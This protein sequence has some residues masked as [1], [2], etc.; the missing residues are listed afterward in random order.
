MKNRK[1][2]KILTI[3]GTIMPFPMNRMYLGEL[4][5]G[6][7]VTLNYFFVGGWTDCF[8]MDKRFDEAMGKRGFSN[9]DIRNSQGR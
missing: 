1:T 9:T 7:L 5:L 2:Y 8:Y 4:W 6:R 3:I